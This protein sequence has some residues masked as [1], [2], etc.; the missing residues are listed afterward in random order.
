M[1]LEARSTHAYVDIKCSTSLNSVVQKMEKK[2]KRLK[3]QEVGGLCGVWLGFGIMPPGGVCSPLYPVCL[4]G[5]G[6]GMLCYPSK[7]SQ[8]PCAPYREV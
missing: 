8:P 3:G 6:I 4:I 7:P 1:P 2:E 5:S